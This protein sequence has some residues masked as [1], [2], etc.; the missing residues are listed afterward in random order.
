MQK[1]K[2]LHTSNCFWY[3]KVQKISESDWPRAFL[4]ITQE[5]DFF[6]DMQFLQNYEGNYGASKKKKNKKKNTHIN[7]L[8]F[9]NS[10]TAYFGVY[11]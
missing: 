10:K 11:F 4:S 8:T 7:G 3:T 1:K 9:A 6:S 2:W 5:P